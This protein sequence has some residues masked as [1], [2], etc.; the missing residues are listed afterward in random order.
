MEGDTNRPLGPINVSRQERQ[1]I[2]RMRQVRQRS[3]GKPWQITVYGT[4]GIVQ[5]WTGQP[6]GT[7]DSG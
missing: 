7:V 3:N 1:V 6:G 4:D 5:I 2:D